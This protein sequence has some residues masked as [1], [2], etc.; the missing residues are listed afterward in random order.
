M[1][2]RRA[3]SPSIARWTSLL[4]ACLT[5][6]IALADDETWTP[7]F[8]ELDLSGWVNVN[9]APGTFSVRDGMIVSTGVPTGVMRT[10]K[11]Y[12]N[13]IL[14]LEYRHMHAGGNAG[15]F[16]W[17]DALTSPGVPFARAIEVQV[18]DGL[19]TE[20][21]TSHGDVFAIHGATMTPDRPHPNGWMRCL[22][23][24]RRAK[25]PGEWNHYRVVCRDGTLKLSV[26]GKQVSGGYDCSPR[27]GYLCLESEGSECHFRNLKIQKLPASEL[28]P[29]QI[30]QGDEG[31]H[32]LY[33]GLDLANWRETTGHAGHWQPKD[34]VL[35]YDGQSEADD[36]NLWSE[37]EF[38]DFTLIVDWRLTGP[39]KKHQVPSVLPTGEEEKNAD[40][41]R[42]LIE[43]DDHGESGIMLRGD[44][45]C[46]VKISCWPIGSGDVPGFR[47]DPS[48]SRAGRAAVTPQVRADHAPGEWNRFHITLRKDRLTVVLN[49]QTVIDDAHVPKVAEHGPLGLV[50]GGSAIE[51]ANVYIK[52][53][54]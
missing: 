36:K 37:K 19:N 2:S 43:I 52:Q 53:L 21:Y 26:N 49:G 14:E 42:K 11:M 28:P 31:F 34:W 24:E 47:A 27:R 12:Q 41:T 30:A 9:C 4:L 45:T 20:N 46:T 51:F 10:E 39:A 44:A 40:G 35:S 22:P 6:Q 38:G 25:G 8:N 48:Q 15:L 32:S 50:D 33:T 23:S 16:V 1:A 3:G 29:E 5:C 54:D 18:L 17:S 13:F 7:L